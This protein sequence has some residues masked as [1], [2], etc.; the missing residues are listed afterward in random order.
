MGFVNPGS[1]ANTAAPAPTAANT[2]ELL[3]EASNSDDESA[4]RTFRIAAAGGLA[5]MHPLDDNDGDG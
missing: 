5:S 4:T 3:E 2:G 1:G